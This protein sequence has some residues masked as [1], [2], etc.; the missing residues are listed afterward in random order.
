M[1]GI[2][3][4]R[5]RAE[6]TFVGCSSCWASNP[7]VIAAGSGTAAV[8]FLRAGNIAEHP[9]GRSGATWTGAATAAI[10][11]RVMVTSSNSDPPSPA[12]RCR[13]QRLTSAVKP[14]GH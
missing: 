5:L 11:V 6:V 8:V 12:C 9:P 13:R 3:F 4:D 14:M 2:D 1:P 7:S 10:V